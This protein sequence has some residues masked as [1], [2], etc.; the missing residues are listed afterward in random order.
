MSA[1]MALKSEEFMGFFSEDNFVSVNS[2]AFY[3]ATRSEWADSVA[4]WHSFIENRS[5]DPPEIRVTPLSADL[6]MNTASA[7]TT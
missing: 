3:F 1:G 6:A 4:S 2:G 5:Y 7:L